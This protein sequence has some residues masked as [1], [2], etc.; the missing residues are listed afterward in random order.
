[1]ISDRDRSV[2]IQKTSNK[3]KKLAVPSCAVLVTIS[4]IVGCVEAKE[5]QKFTPKGEFGVS[6]SLNN[7]HRN[8][9]LSQKLTGYGGSEYIPVPA[10]YDGDGKA[11]LSVKHASG[12]WHI[13][14][15]R[16]G[17]G[18]WD[19]NLEAYG[20]SEY[21]PVPADYDGDGKT[22]LSVKHASGSWHIDYARNGFGSWD[23]NLEAY[24]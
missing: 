12:S 8:F 24:G 19:K 23:T 20:G 2:G 5:S 18:S 13:D 9:L 7:S 1:M 15:A 22:D 4:S 3:L 11:D 17:F 16:N 14:Y 10:D 21:I 6:S